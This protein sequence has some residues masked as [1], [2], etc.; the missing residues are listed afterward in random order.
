MAPWLEGGDQFVDLGL[1][2][3][4]RDQRAGP[5]LEIDLAGVAREFLGV[6][7]AGAGARDMQPGHLVGQPQHVAGARRPM[8]SVERLV[9]IGGGLGVTRG[10]ELRVPRSL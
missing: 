9:E 3:K 8:P 2:E 1:A 4:I 10:D 6:V 7:L 5:L